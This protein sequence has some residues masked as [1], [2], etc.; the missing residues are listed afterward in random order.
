MQRQLQRAPTTVDSVSAL[1][2]L[3]G[4]PSG[5]TR[6]LLGYFAPNDGG[7]GLL[8]RNSSSS[9]TRNGGTIFTSADGGRWERVFSGAINAKWFGARGD[10][11]FA[12]NVLTDDTLSLRAW[13]TYIRDLVSTNPLEAGGTN[14]VGRA[15]GYL[16][17][18]TY[19]V[20]E[21]DAFVLPPPNRTAGLLIRGGGISATNLIFEPSVPG[22]TDRYLIKNTETSLDFAGW[23]D[24][25]FRDLS[26]IGQTSGASFMLSASEGGPQ[27]YHCDRVTFSDFKYGF[28]LQGSN[29]NSEHTWL[30]CGIYGTWT[31]FLWSETSDQFLNYDFIKCNYEVQTGNFIRM[32][33]GGNVTISGGSFISNSP[34][35]LA[36]GTFFRLENPLASWGVQRFLCRGVRFEQRSQYARIILCGWWGGAIEFDSCDFTSYNDSA[37][38]STMISATFDCH[39]S[40]SPGPQIRWQNCSIIGK[41]EYKYYTNAYA[42]QLIAVYEGCEFWQFVDAKDFIVLTNADS[43]TNAGGTSMVSFRNSRGNFSSSGLS[44]RRVAFDTDL[45]WRQS[46][47]ANRIQPKWVSFKTATGANP[48]ASGSV[49]VRLPLD[50]VITKISLYAPAF[51]T[52]TQTA[53][54]FTVRTT[55]GTPTVLHSHAPGTQLKNGFSSQIDKFFVC[56]SDAKRDIDL[57]ANASVDQSTTSFLGLIEYIG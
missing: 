8:R 44:G 57:V 4:I 49:G 29:T 12:N 35:D 16:P 50:A 22:G 48:T 10:Y 21:E 34:A 47:Y 26:F 39:K 56:D 15:E 19:R 32:D 1:E 36:S 2:A 43:N 25:T 42:Q 20:T 41:H 31:H 52:S 24:L 46:T 6:Y 14:Q 5:E 13:A 18:G 7:G 54:S 9:Q 53:W 38:A 55:E 17:P 23:A 11:H 30:N 27:N 40:G 3:T 33:K 37:Y 51:G 45:S 28:R